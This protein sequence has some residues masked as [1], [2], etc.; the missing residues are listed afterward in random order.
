MATNDVTVR[1]TSTDAITVS[2][3]KWVGYSVGSA[4]ERFYKFEPADREIAKRLL[5]LGLGVTPRPK[6]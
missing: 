5:L 6:T 4:S 3:G 2:G 1:A